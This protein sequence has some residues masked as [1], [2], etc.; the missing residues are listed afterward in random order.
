MKKMGNGVN[1]KETTSHL[2]V[3]R[4]TTKRVF[5]PVS[6]WN[7]IKFNQLKNQCTFIGIQRVNSTKYNIKHTKYGYKQ[8]RQTQIY[9]AQQK[10]TSSYTKYTLIQKFGI[11][12][13]LHEWRK[14]HKENTRN[15]L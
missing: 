5:C 3:I 15:I 13:A 9:N 12:A 10:I 6:R 1:V 11:Q 4:P 14:M 7:G 8:S 2:R